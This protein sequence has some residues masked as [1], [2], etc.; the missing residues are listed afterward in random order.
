[1]PLRNALDVRRHGGREQRDLT[2][3]RHL[4][5][6]RIHGIG[7][8][9]GQHLVG[10]IQHHGGD[11]FQRQRAA[12]E[13]I[14]DAAGGADDDVSAATQRIELRCIA[15]AAVDGQHMK[16]GQ[17]DRIFLE[18]L[19]DLDGQFARRHQHQRLRRLL[20]DADARQ[21]GQRKGGGLAGASLCLA[22]DVATGE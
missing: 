20:L 19:G 14:H 10:F 17:A 13:V 4:A 22:E 8:A 6:D 15:L 9:H 12:I 21:D 3:S 16:A 7:K 5:Q 11:A 2:F 1:M 18:G